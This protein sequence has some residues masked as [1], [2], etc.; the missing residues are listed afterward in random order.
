[1]SLIYLFIDTFSVTQS[2]ASKERMEGKRWIWKGCGSKRSWPN[3][4]YYPGITWGDWWKQ[5]KATIACL[6]VEIWIRDSRIR[7]VSVNNSVG[8][9]VASTFSV[10]GYSLTSSHGKMSVPST[11]DLWVMWMASVTTEWPSIR[12]LRAGSSRVALWVMIS[13]H[14]YSHV[15]TWASAYLGKLYCIQ[16]HKHVEWRVVIYGAP[17]IVVQ[18]KRT[19]EKS[20][21][22][23]KIPQYKNSW[24]PT[25]RI[26]SRCVKTYKREG[27]ERRV[28]TTVQRSRVDTRKEW[29]SCGNTRFH[30]RK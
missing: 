17:V 26:L 7:S 19:V 3:L 13:P 29:E 24:K 25:Q 4:R 12:S 22:F 1:M 11:R 14:R 28:E 30:E 10:C 21:N 6:R 15:V 20:T 5:R 9:T 23:S 2:L 16:S 8:C 27:K 18:R